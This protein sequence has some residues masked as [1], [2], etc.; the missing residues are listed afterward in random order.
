MNLLFATSTWCLLRP[1]PYSA[2]ATLFAAI[3]WL[4]GNGPLEGDVLFTVTLQDGVT[5]SDLLSVAAIGIALWGYLH[6]IDRGDSGEGRRPGIVKPRRQTVIIL[7]AT[8]AVALV[9]V[10]T[11]V[12]LGRH[13]TAEKCESVTNMSQ[14]FA[15]QT[16]GSG[17]KRIAVVGDSYSVGTGA[18]NQLQTAWPVALSASLP[19]TV[20]VNGIGGTGFTNGGYCGDDQF[21]SRIADAVKSKPDL[22]IIQGGLNDVG[23]GNVTRAARDTIRLAGST[24][25]VVVGPPTAPAKDSDEERAVDSQLQNAAKA[26]GVTYVST[27]KWPLEWGTDSLHPTTQGHRT[28]ADALTNVLR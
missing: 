24:P 8:L 9:G 6:R 21:A 11:A 14:T 17:S 26:L 10:S 13:K 22:L 5:V 15:A 18:T 2:T 16:F 19:A 3:L 23:S 25:V 20:T 12:Y 1:S 4:F 7:A 27:L 28:F